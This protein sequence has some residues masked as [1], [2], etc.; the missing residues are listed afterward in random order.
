MKNSD[1]FR[2]LPWLAI[3]VLSWLSLFPIATYDA[4]YHLASGQR[5]LDE[6]EIP[7]RGVG[8]ATF[9]DHPWHNQE[10]GFQLIAAAIAGSEVDEHGVRRLTQG[11]IV[12]LILLRA[13]CL[14]ATLALLS[15]QMARTGVEPLTRSVAL[16][17][18]A[19]LTFGNLF[20]AVRPQILTYLALVGV[21][22]LL[23]RD[24]EGERW[25]GW[26]TLAVIAVW[27]NIHGA[28]LIGIVVLGA[29]AT[30]ETLEAIRARFQGP[31]RGRA[32]RLWLVTALSPLAAC[33]N[34]HG[35]KQL[36]HPFEYL[37]RPEIYRGNAEWSKP[38]FIHLPLFMLTIAV[39]V[40]TLVAAGKRFRA[41]DLIRAAGFLYMFSGAIRHLPLAVLIVVPILAAAAGTAARLGGWRKN[42]EPTGSG[43]GSP[44]MRGA[45]ALM[46]TV[47][48]VALSGSFSRPADQRFVTLRPDFSFK[49][50]GTLPENAVN[51]LSEQGI[52]GAVF[53]SYR[54][55]GFLMFRLY[56]QDRAFMDGRNDIYEMY[57]DE[58][59]NPILFTQPGWERLWREAVAEHDVC[60]VL[61]E[62]RD[63]LARALAADP[64]WVVPRRNGV[65]VIDGTPGAGAT[66][67]LVRRSKLEGTP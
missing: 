23:Q 57:R 33:L 66:A 61:I 7:S 65:P 16:I 38:D 29:E 2:Y 34:P 37:L 6:G 67:F 40:V 58:V 19:F 5:I 54:L 43:W 55:G 30:G 52:E 1:P 32:I 53:N 41:A 46:L 35:Y 31:H 20:W 4:H 62:E 25:A 63:P 36:T 27:A 14:A 44:A 24:R 12:A 28:F 64:E 49:P 15:A 26:A 45:A 10:W 47:V 18:A 51:Y 11:G 22:Y 59:Y 21:T 9:G 13:L 42:L 8:S 17:L 50:F 3:A 48:I 56:P 39:L 60:C